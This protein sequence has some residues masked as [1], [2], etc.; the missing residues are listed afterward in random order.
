MCC[1]EARHGSAEVGE[2]HQRQKR[3]EE[4]LT[5]YELAPRS[6]EKSLAF[7]VLPIPLGPLALRATAAPSKDREFSHLHNEENESY[8]AGLWSY[9]VGQNVCS[10]SSVRC[11]E[12]S[13]RTCWPTPSKVPLAANVEQVPAPSYSPLSFLTR[14]L[15]PTYPT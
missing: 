1:R 13:K 7:G 4:G 6:C 15:F 11:Y 3:A 10:G 14:R 9:C 8:F 12:K 2:G 5:C